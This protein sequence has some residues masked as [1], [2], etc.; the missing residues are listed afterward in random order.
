MS[1]RGAGWRRL[2]T[3]ARLA[4]RQVWRTKGS[5]A[6]V[7]LLIVLPVAAL[8]GGGIFWQSHIPTPQQ[9]AALELGRHQA[10]L[11]VVGGS[12]PTRWQSVDMPYE[13]GVE[14]D[15]AGRAVN[16]EGPRPEDPSQ[17]L[18]SGAA[19]RTVTEWGSLYVETETGIGQVAATA[20]DVWDDAFEGRY[21]VVDGAAPTRGDEA[22][23]S[24]G[25]L[26]RMGAD[27]GDDVV[28]VDSDRAF[29]VTGTMRR[30]DA[31]P[32]DPEVFLPSRAADVVGGQ[33]RWFIED[34]QPD[35]AALGELNRAG[36]IAFAQD[37]AIDPPPGARVATY[38]NGD[39][40]DMTML[41][42]GLLLAVFSGYLVVLLAGAAFAVSAR[43]QQQ[44]L[45]VAAS[46]GAG[47]SDVFRVVVMQGTVLGAVAGVIGIGLGAAGAWL[48]LELTDTGAVNSFWG[49]WGYRVP[50]LALAGVAVFAVVVGTLSAVAPARTATRGD[51]LGALRGSRR[52]AVLQRKRPWWGLGL[53]IAGLAATVAGVLTLIALNTADPVDYSHPLRIT[54]MMA[55]A[56]GPVVFQIGFLVAGHWV[57]V[58]VGRPLARIGLAPRLASRDSAA[59]PS[60]VVPA[61]A[62]IAACVFI[63][64][65][66]AATTALTAA[67]NARTYWYNGPLHS[68]SVSVFQNGPDPAP[69]ALAAAEELLG[70]TAPRSTALV[71]APTST[72]FDAET[73]EV[74]DP[75]HPVY[76]LRSQSWRNCDT[77]SDDPSA[78]MNGQLS[79]VAADD[80]AVLLDHP[81]DEAT[82]RAYR[83]G[84]ALTTTTEY[85]TPEG[86]VVITEWTE[87]GRT[88]FYNALSAVDWEDESDDR[89]ARVPRPLAERAI[90][91]V[92]LDTGSNHSTQ[93]LIAPETAK[94]L[95]IAFAPSQLVGVYDE[96]LSEA[97]L[98]RL[99]AEASGVRLA[100]GA[101]VWVMT[102]RGPDP[103]APWLWLIVAIAGV[104]VVGASAVVLGLARF[105]RRPD[106]ATLTAV[107]GS[108]VLRRNVN[109]WQAA[110]IVGIGAVVGT[111]AGLIPVWGTAQSSADFLRLADLPWPWL[112]I[113]GVGLPVAITAV[114]W[115]VPPRRPE[116]TRRTAIA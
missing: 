19:V 86:E 81:V 94:T 28:L 20:G 70:S 50:W 114:A 3:D 34:W 41:M 111:I 68:V 82:L 67:G 75:D 47:R 4:R 48:G 54:A 72:A 45:A 26:E 46:V 88:D 21:V 6:L 62:A 8:S 78:A 60:R 27:I 15:D 5:S 13:Y 107:G 97:A 36:F 30:A 16:V 92:H 109:A 77:C 79:I 31:R 35:L 71:M 91:A 1:G 57:L 12:D 44:T 89:F 22:M 29:T 14:T 18:P 101:A 23:V 55:V 80:V 99:M 11:Q 38:S 90:S 63:A 51:V 52:P 33:E 74:V 32:E 100:D 39:S 83:E 115:L 116:L 105:E 65:Y 42:T 85:T 84:A 49:N 108:R 58:R 40:Q 102:E 43:R 56:F 53:M 76:A 10:W 25:L 106:D 7:V 64:S 66:A 113:L 9:K 95:G 69:E 24:P 61:F 87:Q 112:A 73:G 59:N 2:R 93:V 17:F 104:L 110:I 96:P 103:V 37:L 98:D